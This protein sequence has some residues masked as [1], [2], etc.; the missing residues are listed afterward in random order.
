MDFFSPKGMT[1][2]Q[3]RKTSFTLSAHAREGYSLSVSLSLCS[4][5]SKI[6]AIFGERAS[7]TSAITAVIYAGT[8]Q[9]LNGLARDLLAHGTLY[10]SCHSLRV[11]ASLQRLLSFPANSE[12][13]Y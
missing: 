3:R 8:A 6:E 1:A 12:L 11:V 2:I 9:S 10:Q 13:V 5:F 7:G 4:T